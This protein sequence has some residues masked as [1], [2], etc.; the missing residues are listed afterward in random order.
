MK[1]NLNRFID[2]QSNIYKQV[3]KELTQGRKTSHWMWYIFPQIKGL[4][5]SPM[6]QF[7]AISSLEEAKEYLN[8]AVLGKRLIECCQILLTLENKTAENIFGSIDAMK[9]KSSMT[10]FSLVSDN[11]VFNRVLEMYFN[12]V[13]DTATLKIVETNMD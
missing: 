13:K 6:A 11:P 5:Y 10:L 7:Y 9:L 1:Y 4:G 2:A 12:G 8:H 3:V